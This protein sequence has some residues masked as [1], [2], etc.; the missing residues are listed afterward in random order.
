MRQIASE[1]GHAVRTLRRARWTTAVALVTLGLG[2]GAVTAV[3]SV[4]NTAFFRP[5]PYPD[6]NRI[7]ALS[8]Q[9]RGSYLAFSEMPP[10]AVEAVRQGSHTFSRVGT[11]NE[12]FATLVRREGAVSIAVTEVDSAIA[13]LLQLHAAHGRIPAG[14]EIARGA[15]VAVVSDRLWRSTLN[16][17][18]D[19]VGSTIDVSGATYTVVGVLPRGVRCYERSDVLVPMPPQSVVAESG[20]VP[21][22]IGKLAPGV[23]LEQARREMRLVSHRLAAEYPAEFG[24]STVVVRN[25]MFEVRRAAV[26]R[27]ALLF[28]AAA[29][30]VMLVAWSNV[31]NLLVARAVTRRPEMA[32]RASLGASRAR[33]VRQNLLESAILSALAGAVGVLVAA[34]GVG[35]LVRALPL[36]HA[37]SWLRFGVDGRVLA[38]AI[39]LSMLAVAFVG[40]APALEAT[41]VRLAGVLQSGGGAGVLGDRTTK[42]GRWVVI[43]ELALGVVLFATALLIARTARAL[44]DVDPGYDADRVMAVRVNFDGPRYDQESART[45]FVATLRDAVEGRPGVVLAAMRGDY[46]AERWAGDG[47]AQRVDTAGG[48]FSGLAYARHSGDPSAGAAKGVRSV[49]QVVSP[50]YFRAMGIAVVGG[51][52]FST[53]D[54]AGG[55]P[56]AVVSQELA[57]QLWGEEKPVGR[58][59]HLGREDGTLVTVV[60]VV[61][62][63]RRPAFT[64]SGA[65]A[66]PEADLY[67]PALQA[68]PQMPEL[69]VRLA[70]PSAPV[71]RLLLEQ[72]RGIDP[73]QAVTI[74]T[75]ADE[76]A[77]LMSSLR[78][79]FELPILIFAVV[80]FALAVIG[81]Y[82]V[83]A[84]NTAQRTREIGVRLALGGS[85]ARVRW[86]VMVGGAR[87]VAIGLTLGLGM[88]VVVAIALRHFLWGTSPLDP[89]T[90]AAAAAIFGSVALAACYLPAY[91]AT[92]LSPSAAL[93]EL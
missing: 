63:V 67:F 74:R 50:E 41:R 32:L 64:P 84:Y 13:P 59:L 79:L 23:K 36:Q 58:Q 87:L 43:A 14:E 60:G 76:S 30:C 28:V 92:R 61:R 48:F 21:A 40:V 9:T 29:L 62:D 69:L 2:I 8:V 18:P 68:V 52:V 20:R 24:A 70:G 82:S 11:F 33:L 80:A 12:R 72:A 34:W 56:V 89:F 35:L 47:S 1:I 93:R 31:A 86:A 5:P 71:A 10:V 25:G 83:V 51:R 57:R 91:R 45:R 6:G 4:V 42:R 27:F 16:E 7:V 78:L 15:P 55:M 65:K 85:V 88:A 66:G 81:V 19:V 26:T 53:T 39:A 77:Q 73:T 75:L 37:P 46:A 54:R 22:A 38:F 17:A 44:S 90:L 3:F 49:M